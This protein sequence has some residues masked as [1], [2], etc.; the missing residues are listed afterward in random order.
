MTVTELICQLTKLLIKHGDRE[1]AVEVNIETEK[2]YDIVD[3]TTLGYPNG[4]HFDAKDGQVKID[5]QN[6]FE[7]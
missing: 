1:V 7:V 4:A 6:Y 2:D 5:L 3:W